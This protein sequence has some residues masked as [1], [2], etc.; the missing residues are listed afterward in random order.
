MFGC[1]GNPDAPSGLT[2]ARVESNGGW[3]LIVNGREVVSGSA[4]VGYMYDLGS[5]RQCASARLSFNRV[6]APAAGYYL[7]LMVGQGRSTT[8]A[9][10]GVIEV[11]GTG[12]TPVQYPRG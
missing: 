1:G 9:S 8:S 5:G 11:C 10:D 4:S 2:Q 6:Q 7:T 12:P 3:H